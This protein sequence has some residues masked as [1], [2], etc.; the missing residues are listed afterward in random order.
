MKVKFITLGC[1]TNYYESQAMSEL[2]RQKGYIIADKNEVADI[3][4]INTCTVTGTGAQKSR[5]HIRKAKKENPSAIIAVTGCYAQTEPETVATLEGVDVVIGTNGKKQIVEHIEKAINGEKV[6]HLEDMTYCREYEELCITNEQSRI[7]ATIKI[8]DGCDNFC[9]YCIIPYARG[10]VRSRKL[11]NVISEVKKLA[12]A[13]YPEIVL[14]GIHLDSYGKDFDFKYKLIDVI[15]EVS[16]ISGIKRIRLGSLEPVVITEDFVLR[17]KKLDNF[18]PHFHLSLQSGCDETLKRMNRHYTTGDYEKAVKLLKENFADVAITTDIMVG[19]PGETEEEFSLSYNFCKKIEFMQMHVFKY[20]KRKGT[21]AAVMENQIPEGIKDIRSE[22][23]LNLSK[24][25]REK[26]YNKY[27]GKKY[28][29]L[30]EEKKKGNLYHGT[31]PNYLDV[32][33]K[34]D[35]DISNKIVET[36][37]E[38]QKRYAYAYRF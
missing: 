15:E 14:T 29:V 7:R 2:F 28:A 19:F 34:S 16:K 23:M 38:W 32:Y 8:Q 26:F 3:Y 30:I 33:V 21:K 9:T 25:M 6:L 24:E 10:R 4:V 22:K 35:T 36:V 13:G 12:A 20:S 5:Q 1:K 11:E 17:A 27:K 18:C 37:I 31:L